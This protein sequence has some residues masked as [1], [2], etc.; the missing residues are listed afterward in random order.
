[1]NEFEYFIELGIVR[2]ITKDKQ[3]S[4]NLTEESKRKFKLLNKAIE[5]MGGR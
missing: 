1:M 5:K 4:D 3:R 2:K